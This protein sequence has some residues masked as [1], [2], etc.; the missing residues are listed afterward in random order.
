[1]VGNYK[2][3]DIVDVNLGTPPDQV[4]GHEQGYSRPSIVVKSFESLGLLIVLPISGTEQK[5]THYTIVELQAGT[6]GL[7]KKSFVLCHQIRAVSLKRIN[8]KR[9]AVSARELSKVITVLR[10]TLD[11]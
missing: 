2:T 10:D 3:G 1:M 7:T 8:R 11:I 5:Y 4:Q 6:G 9:G